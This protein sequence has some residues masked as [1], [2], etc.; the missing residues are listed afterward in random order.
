MH[1]GASLS[2][3]IVTVKHKS[4]NL[5]RSVIEHSAEFTHNAVV[6]VHI[7]HDPTEKMHNVLWGSCTQKGDITPTNAVLTAKTIIFITK[8][9]KGS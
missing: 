3:L 2:K 1:F 7:N 5:L 6:D 4:S 8:P 9:Q